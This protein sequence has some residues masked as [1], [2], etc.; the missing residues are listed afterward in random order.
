MPWI[1]GTVVF[2]FCFSFDDEMQVYPV[3]STDE[4]RYERCVARPVRADTAR[5]ILKSLYCLVVY[6]FRLCQIIQDNIDFIC[7]EPVFDLYP[8][9]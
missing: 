2:R 6:D 8:E 9:N 3:F 5:F 7:L 4:F 1:A